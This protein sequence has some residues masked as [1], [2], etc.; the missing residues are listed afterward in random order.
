VFDDGNDF[1]FWQAGAEK[2]RSAMFGEALFALF[3][4]QKSGVVLTVRVFNSDIFSAAN[5][6]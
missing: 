4:L 1:I 2:D 5:A 6:E 3:A